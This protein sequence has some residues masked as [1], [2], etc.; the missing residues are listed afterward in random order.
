MPYH[1]TK[2]KATYVK[3][4]LEELICERFLSAMANYCPKKRKRKRNQI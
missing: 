3:A 4:H 1:D 2:P